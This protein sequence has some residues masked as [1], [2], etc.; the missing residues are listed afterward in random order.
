MEDP[1]P[2]PANVADGTSGQLQRSKERR[3][4]LQSPKTL[5][6]DVRKS[7]IFKRF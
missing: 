3:F 7:L 6:I 1:K 2:Q 5:E 4:F